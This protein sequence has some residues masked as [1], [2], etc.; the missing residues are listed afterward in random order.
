MKDCLGLWETNFIEPNLLFFGTLI[1]KNSSTFKD[2]LKKVHILLN[3][4][5]LV[6]FLF[7]CSIG[8]TRLVPHVPSMLKLPVQVGWKVGGWKTPSSDVAVF[9]GAV[10]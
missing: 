9:S 1:H 7:C 3:R 2:V 8:C 4:V 10:V 5:V 6:S